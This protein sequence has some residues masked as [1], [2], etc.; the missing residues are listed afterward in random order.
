M[1]TESAVTMRHTQPRHVLIMLSMFLLATVAGLT[2]LR[3]PPSTDPPPVWRA[4]L[5]AERSGEAGG[6][7]RRRSVALPSSIVRATSS[8]TSSK[9]VSGSI[10]IPGQSNIGR[11]AIMMSCACRPA[12]VSCAVAAELCGC[13]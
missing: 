13:G 12:Q 4:R 1:A 2:A 6:E 8:A 3:P 11:R 7:S 9:V 5:A 10:A